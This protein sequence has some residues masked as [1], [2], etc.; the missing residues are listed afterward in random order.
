MIVTWQVALRIVL[1][2]ILA[3]ILQLAFFSQISILGA[4]PDVLPVIA[5]ALGLLGGGVI[6]AV[7]GFA[8]GFLTD[9]LLL[10]TLGVS[11]IVLLTVGY[12]AGRWRETFDI[13]S[14]LLP[15]LL[16]GGLAIVGFAM[17]AAFALIPRFVQAPESTGYGFGDS[18]T[19]GAAAFKFTG[20]ASNTLV[21]FAGFL[22]AINSAHAAAASRDMISTSELLYGRSVLGLSA[23]S[24]E[25]AEKIFVA[26]LILYGLTIGKRLKL[27]LMTILFVGLYITF[28]RTAIIATVLYFLVVFFMWTIKSPRRMPLAVVVGLAVVGVCAVYLQ[29]IID[30]FTR[31]TGSVTYSEL[32]RI[33]YGQAALEDLMASPLTGNGSLNWTVLDPFGGTL[34]H[35]HNSLMMLLVKHGLLLGTVFIVFVLLGTN[36]RYILPLGV[37]LLFSITQYFFFWNMSLADLLLHHFTRFGREANAFK[38]REAGM[39]TPWRRGQHD[40]PNLPSPTNRSAR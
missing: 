29:P 31:G 15:P 18:V 2:V 14:S 36:R 16:A 3:V 24:S 38:R 5:V 26:V 30:Q 19:T 23:N 6:G 20:A 7:C 11:S 9:S 12:L 4:T 8:L 35:A 27:V 40:L 39:A 22:I 10:Q 34:Q 28:N 21:A 25:F 37:M 1:V 13:T 17:F 33:Y 32:A